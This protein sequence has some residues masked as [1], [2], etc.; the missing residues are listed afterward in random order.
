MV[1][2]G[3]ERALVD[4]CGEVERSDQAQ[5]GEHVKE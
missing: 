5:T 1:Y 2:C 4:V 3:R